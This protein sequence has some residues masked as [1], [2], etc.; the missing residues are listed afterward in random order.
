LGFA[1]WI[2][3]PPC[4]FDDREEFLLTCVVETAFDGRHGEDESRPYLPGLSGVVAPMP[5]IRDTLRTY[6]CTLF[7]VSGAHRE[8]I[9]H[10]VV[11]SYFV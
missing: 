5:V 4:I 2:Q 11:Q 6:A 10:S 7:S 9:L 8:M 1:L 3:H